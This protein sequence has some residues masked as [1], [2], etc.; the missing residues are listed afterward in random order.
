MKIKSDIAITIY[1][2]IK[3]EG[4]YHE[5][6]SVVR[7]SYAYD[8]TRGSFDGTQDD[9]LSQC[10]SGWVSEDDSQDIEIDAGD[11]Y[12]SDAL[13]YQHILKLT[14]KSDDESDFEGFWVTSGV[15]IL[16]NI[17]ACL[18]MKLN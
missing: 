14:E 2:R 8:T 17:C 10:E 6:T 5:T 15:I 3:I 7:L 16:L 9:I 4:I 18:W 13:S 1:T 11:E 12:Y